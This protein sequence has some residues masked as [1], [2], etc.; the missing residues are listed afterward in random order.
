M[1]K[2]LLYL[3]FMISTHAYTMAS[4]PNDLNKAIEAA[5]R[6]HGLETEPE[7]KHFFKQAHV[8]YP[9]KKIALLAFKKEQNLQ[10]WAKNKNKT[11]RYIHTYPLTAS[12][13]ALGP[14][15]KEHDFQIPEG[16]YKLTAFN[17]FSQMHLSMK[18]NYP[19][20]FDKK[21]ALQEGRKQLGGNI[22]LHGKAESVGCLAIGN[23]AIN[24]IFMLSHQVGLN[25]V[26]L[27]IAPN[28]LRLKKPKTKLHTQPRWLPELYQRIEKKLDA[29]QIKEQV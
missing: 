12:S 4:T 15:L 9:P 20:A 2:L 22:F 23:H 27:I 13:G 16:I 21:K 25:Q 5:I 11:W 24:Q 18:I 7:L 19:N 14:K 6:H 10:L 26:Q 28:D 29:F 8:S 1:P 3:L 17:P